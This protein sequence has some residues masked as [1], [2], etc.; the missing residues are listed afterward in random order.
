MSCHVPEVFG[1]DVPEPV[2]REAY[3]TRPDI[4]FRMGWETG[5]HSEPA[6]MDMNLHAVRGQ[7][8]PKVVLYQLDSEND[9]MNPHG[10]LLLHG[11]AWFGTRNRLMVVWR[12]LR[13]EIPVQLEIWSGQASKRV[14]RFNFNFEVTGSG[15]ISSQLAL[16][17]FFHTFFLALASTR[18]VDI[19]LG[20]ARWHFAA[21]LPWTGSSQGPSLRD[22]TTVAE[23]AVL[24]HMVHWLDLCGIRWLCETGV[25]ILAFVWNRQRSPAAVPEA[26]NNIVAMWNVEERQA[27]RGHNLWDPSLDDHEVLDLLERCRPPTGSPRCDK[28]PLRNT[29]L[30]HTV[31]SLDVE[32]L[33]QRETRPRGCQTI[34]RRGED[35]GKQTATA[36][37]DA[38]TLQQCR[39][40][41]GFYQL[42]LQL[43]Y[44]MN[45]IIQD[46]ANT[47]PVLSR[48][49]QRDT[50][51]SRLWPFFSTLHRHK[52]SR[53]DLLRR[54]FRQ[55][56]LNCLF[57]GR[58]NN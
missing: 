16:P 50:S 39:T 12:R 1:L 7:D 53:N 25:D 34:P 29:A 48:Y 38:G 54:R 36:R 24:G 51:A 4:S 46:M 23:E 15:S 31:G 52:R 28:N 20:G 9:P 56:S 13:C 35:E 19:Q 8:E 18:V 3:I 14:D 6:F 41:Q 21:K 43:Q 11:S 30:A 27:T 10:T 40:I 57:A 55:L 2:I 37:T 58:N 32:E 44:R 17:F 49:H 26:T 45:F 5:R 42:E 22:G 33:H 47:K